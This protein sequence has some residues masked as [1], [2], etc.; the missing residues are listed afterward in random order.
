VIHPIIFVDE[1]N[2]AIPRVSVRIRVR[3][4]VKVRVRGVKI[5]LMITIEK[6]LYLGLKAF[7]HSR[8]RVR[9]R[10]S[11]SCNQNSPI[12][13]RIRFSLS[14]NQ[15]SPGSRDIHGRASNNQMYQAHTYS[16]HIFGSI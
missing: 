14:C 1:T 12:R 13:V 10:F 16:R 2:R 11:L 9:I 3:V 4:K 5:P 6:L 8:G 15:D 7:L